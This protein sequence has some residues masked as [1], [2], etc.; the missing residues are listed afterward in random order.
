[1]NRLEKLLE[2]LEIE[3]NE[4]F[5]LY[6]TRALAYRVNE[7]LVLEYSSDDGWEECSIELLDLFRSD[8]PISKTPPK[9]KT[10]E[11]HDVMCDSV[12]DLYVIDM[13]GE[14][15][16]EEDQAMVELI[17][18]CVLQGNVGT[19]EELMF[20]KEQRA[21]EAEVR[22][23]QKISPDT[24]WDGVNKHWIAACKMTDDG[25][26]SIGSTTSLKDSKYY[27]PDKESLENMLRMVTPERY[28]KY[29]FEYQNIENVEEN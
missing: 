14:I 5:Y 4:V 17:D 27:F 12:E 9:T 18:S 20:L 1:M 16:L 25:K 24:E 19:R 29:I 22:Y 3:V 10:E 28:R 6:N 7:S 21:V 15:Y 13:D 23:L 11:L 26:I 8:I 2:I